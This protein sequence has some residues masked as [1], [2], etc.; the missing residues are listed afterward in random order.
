MRHGNSGRKFSR[1]AS[2]RK[3]MFANMAVALIT[4]E[5]IVTTLPKA[6]D[7]RPIVEKLVTLGKRGDLHARRQAIA[8]LRDVEAAKKLFDTLG[9]RYQER[10]GGYL[11]VLKAGF[12]HGDNA[13]V[14]VI[15]FVERDVDA[16]GASDRARAAAEEAASEGVAA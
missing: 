10:Q 14:A 6:K 2:H 4:H 5:Q 16:K 9:P 11:R 7:L 12:R 1:T 13:P 3:A 15:E 8:Q